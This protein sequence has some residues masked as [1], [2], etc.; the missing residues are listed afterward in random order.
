MNENIKNQNKKGNLS[1]VLLII[2]SAACSFGL[3]FVD[4]KIVA[5]AL[6]LMTAA[7]LIAT[8]E[9]R[10]ST[11]LLLVAVISLFFTE[12]GV[13]LVALMLSL[14]VGCGAFARVLEKL[15]SSFLWA[16][17]VAA[18]AVSALV[19]KSALMPMLA[20]GFALPSLALKLSFSKKYTRAAGICLVSGAFMIGAVIF[21]LADVYIATGSISLEFFE[22]SAE[23]Y[24]RSFT[25]LLMQFEAVNPATGEAEVLFSELDAKNI[26]SEMVSLFPAFFVIMCNA[27]AW[28]SQKLMYLLVKRE[29]ELHKFED[30]MIA[31]ILSPMAGITFVASFVL[32]MTASAD[33]ALV[34]TVSENIFCI[35]VP[36]LAISG[37]MFQLAKI[38][39]L[40][41][42]AWVIIPFAILAFVNIALALVLAAC[43]G[44][45]YSIA[46]P[47]YQ[48][49]N[50]HR[51]DEE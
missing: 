42:G 27:G 29:G 36:G 20:L 12:E 50:S 31:L 41:R 4:N 10:V 8:S 14:V 7:F 38:S 17:P 16:I 46:A 45:Y 32:M 21:L 51:H 47:V 18:F 13:T 34:Y 22:E 3:P 5:G 26:A 28:V 30:K 24:R 19:T 2:V 39:R 11:V 40:R 48:F 6:L 25:D 43:L 35:F 44:A 49:I 9:R 15:S 33:Q 23:L 1:T 37:I